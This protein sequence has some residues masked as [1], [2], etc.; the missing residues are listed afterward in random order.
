MAL[1]VADLLPSYAALAFP[2]SMLVAVTQ[3]SGGQAPLVIFSQAGHYAGHFRI[4]HKDTCMTIN[5]L[6]GGTAEYMGNGVFM[7]IQKDHYGIVHDVVVGEEDVQS[8]WEDLKRR[9]EAH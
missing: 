7:L 4:T 2:Q 6:D 8:L 9:R 1:N 5:I 3:A